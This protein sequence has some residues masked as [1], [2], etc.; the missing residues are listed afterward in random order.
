MRSLSASDAALSA[1]LS[2]AIKRYAS[3]ASDPYG[4]EALSGLAVTTTEACTVATALL[5]SQS[6]FTPFEFAVW[7]ASG[8]R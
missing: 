7:F 1:A 5:R 3:L 4:D 2:D 6:L 8:G